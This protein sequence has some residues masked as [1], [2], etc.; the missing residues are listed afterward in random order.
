MIVLTTSTPISFEHFAHITNDLHIFI[1]LFSF[2]PDA[3]ASV[4]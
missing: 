2:F 4:S 3:I 1:I